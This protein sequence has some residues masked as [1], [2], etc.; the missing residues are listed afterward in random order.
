[1]A[2]SKRRRRKLSTARTTTRKI[3]LPTE[4]MEAFK[5]PRQYFVEKFG[6]EPGPGDP[7]FFDPDATEPIRLTKDGLVE[8]LVQEMQKSGLSPS[9]IEQLR[10]WLERWAGE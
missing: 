9:R 1:M 8:L 5:Q 3:K 2:R 10:P 4:V 6:R 7:V